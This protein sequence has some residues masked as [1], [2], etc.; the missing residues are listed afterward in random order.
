[1]LKVTLANLGAHK[2]RLLSTFAAVLIGV[3]FLSG[4]LIQTQTLQ[5]KFDT[6]FDT[7]SAQVDAAVRSDRSTTSP[8]GGTIRP[9]IPS[10]VLDRVRSVS[11]VADAQPDWVAPAVVVGTNGKA[12]GTLGPPQLGMTWHDD[13]ALSPMRLVEGRAP[14][15]T[16]QVVLDRATATKGDLAVGDRTTVLVPAPIEVTVVG[17]ATFGSQDGAAG[18]TSALF[19]EAGARAHL[20]TSTGA[21]STGTGTEAADPGIDR[22]LLSFEPGANASAVTEQVRRAAGTGTETIDRATY[23]AENRDN[24]DDIMGFLRPTL[25]TF[26]LIALLVA[27]FSIYNTFAIIVAQRSREAALLRAIGASRRQTLFAVVVESFLVGLAASIAGVLAGIGVAAGLGTVFD[28]QGMDMPGGLQL[29]PSTLLVCVA[30]GTVLTMLCALGPAL[31]A[32]RVAPIEALRDAAIDRSGTSRSRRL[33]G[34]AA[35]IASFAAILG[36]TAGHR[37]M[38]MGGLGVALAVLA[39]VV[40]G[41]LVAGP[42]G[43][44]LGQPLRLRG[45]T[46]DLARQN[47]VRNPRRTASSSSA[48]MIGVAIVALFTVFASSLKSTVDHQVDEQFGGDLVIRSTTEL[49]LD[50]AVARQV[51]GLPEVERAAGLASTYVDVDGR[52]VDVGLSDIPAAARLLDVGHV[53]GDLDRVTGAA[54]AVSESTAED[55][56]WHVGSTVP[57]TFVDGTTAQVTVQAIYGVTDLAGDYLLPTPLAEGRGTAITDN[58]V[59]VDLRSGVSI[60]EGRRVVGQ[61]VDRLPTADVQDRAEFA[62]FIGGQIDSI[63]YVVYGMLALSILI[64]LMGIANTLSLSTFERTRELGLLRAVGQVRGQTRSMVRLESVIVAAYGTLVGLAIGVL[65]AWVIVTAATG[66][67]IRFHLPVT[68]LVVVLALGAGAGVLAGLRPAARAAKLDPLQAIAAV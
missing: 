24:V 52:K 53:T 47:A 42:V 36:A 4:V 29:T 12:V 28:G 68:Q 56:G 37:G 40:A 38:V 13:P 19:S 44:I 65:G 62:A 51:A 6:L 58:L 61:V 63:L 35:A 50:P 67:G 54:M 48:L 41:P 59:L 2:R 32:S 5:H 17:I 18:A 16:D 57:V 20:A 14:V 60:A 39:F 15:G 43:R 30:V 33:L 9:P 26:A 31:R 10:A 21:T 25:L 66:D 34:I 46:G 1:M 7:S 55:R 64:A 27:S 11:G 23:R 22:I 49:G 45:L 8:D 3:A